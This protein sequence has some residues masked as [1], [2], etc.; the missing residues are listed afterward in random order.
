M[1][2]KRKDGTEKRR[3]AR[4]NLISPTD[5]GKTFEALE[6]E[7]AASGEYKG[8]TRLL[9]DRHKIA[10]AE[11]V[12]Q[13][14][15][16]SERTQRVRDAHIQTMS[17]ALRETENPLLPLLVMPVGETFYVIDGHHRLASYDNAGWKKKIPVEVFQ[18]TLPKARV[19]ALGSNSKNKLPMSFEE[20]REAAW[21][22]TKGDDWG[23]S[24]EQTADAAGVSRRT[25][26]RMRA[27]WKRLKDRVTAEGTEAV[28]RLTWLRAQRMEKGI[29]DD[30]DW[31]PDDWKLEKANELVDK[32][33]KHDIAPLMLR[34][35][36]ITAMALAMLCG[37]H[38][39]DLVAHL[40]S[41]WMADEPEAAEEALGDVKRSFGP[42]NPTEDFDPGD[43]ALQL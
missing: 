41:A 36:E 43:P 25:V 18:G 28:E 15:E 9:V 33:H 20:K 11:K 27:V 22:I 31:D 29:E 32:W 19:F 24:A 23:L 6:A 39:G 42:F 26:F 3:V 1:A 30:G 34:D 16:S 8:P 7:I 35:S 10:Q 40:A 4:A 2:T 17:T 13:W 38:P 14:R 12:F 37:G 5:S 21:R